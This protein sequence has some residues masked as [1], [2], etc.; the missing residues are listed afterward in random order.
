MHVEAII[1]PIKIGNVMQWWASTW[2]HKSR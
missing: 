2:D 1:E